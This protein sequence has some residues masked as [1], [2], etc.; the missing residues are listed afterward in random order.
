MA[1][2]NPD[3]SNPLLPTTKQDDIGTKTTDEDKMCAVSPPPREAV[4]VGLPVGDYVMPRSQWDSGLF[5]CLG[6][7]DDFY[8]SDL[9]VCLLGTMAPCV[10]YGTNAERLESD[11]G[12]FTN[13]CMPYTC[14]YFTG[15]W[16]FGSN[17]LAPWLSYRVRTAMRRRFNL[18]GSCETFNRTCG[19]CGGCYE[20]EV[21]REQLETACDLAT[22]GLC[23]P[24]AL[25]QEGRELRR[26]LPHPGFNVQQPILFMIPPGGQAMG[27]D[28]QS[29]KS[30]M[31]PA[32]AA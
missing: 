4:A 30:S 3:E 21:Q 16:L 32:D 19:C 20:N 17:I 1:K 24:C 10:L 31:P 18:E 23:H 6:R 7:Q 27:R 8:S 14:L 12:A 26:R 29:E 22:H 9:E 15:S 5:S 13:H 25:C 11:S 2:S 28:A